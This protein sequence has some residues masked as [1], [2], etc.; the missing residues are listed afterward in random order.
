MIK[1]HKGLYFFVILSV[2]KE[3]INTNLSREVIVLNFISDMSLT[4][5]G[6]FVAVAVVAYFGYGYYIK[7]SGKYKQK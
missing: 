1:D 7:R 6:I 2:L 5:L 3:I 4:V